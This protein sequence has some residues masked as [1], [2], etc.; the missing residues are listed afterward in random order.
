MKYDLFLPGKLNPEFIQQFFPSLSRDKRVIVGPG[1]GRDAAV[2]D[3]GKTCLVVKTDPITFTSENLGWYT[4][5][6]NAN[7]IACMG[8][9]PRWFL[10]TLLLPQKG[11]S[12]ILVKR[13]F[14]ELNSACQTLRISLVGGHTEVTARVDRP[15]MVGEMI[16]EVAREKLVDGSG[17]KVGDLVLLTKGIAIEGT[18][19]IYQEKNEELKARF[20]QKILNRMRN[21]IH[22]PGISVVKEALLASQNVRIHSMHDPTEGGLKTG[23]WELAYNSGV[24]IRIE[25]EKIPILE[26]TKAVCEL[27]GLDPLGLLASGSL[28]LVIDA[29]QIEKLCQIYEKEGIR[30]RVIGEVVPR[31][32]GVKIIERKKE[33]NLSGIYQDELNRI[34]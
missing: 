24:G 1:I 21:L 7:D 15:L 12:K 11:T 10:V 16:G 20:S 33:L 29:R 23:L 27:Y 25:K 13:I 9:T 14:R 8:A 26:E 4:V 30:Y 22:S 19:L 3:F 18:H 2:I 28:L 34:L 17:V 32:K 5:N 6:I 31:E